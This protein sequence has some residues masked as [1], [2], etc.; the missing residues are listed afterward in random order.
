MINED[1]QCTS[2]IGWRGLPACS[3]GH[4][5]LEKVVLTGNLVSPVARSPGC[6]VFSALSRNSGRLLIDESKCGEAIIHSLW[7]WKGYWLANTQLLCAFIVFVVT[8]PDDIWGF[9]PLCDITE[10]PKL[11]H[12][13]HSLLP[14]PPANHFHGDVE[15]RIFSDDT[16]CSFDANQVSSSLRFLSYWFRRDSGVVIP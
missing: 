2:Y 14:V 9:P 3:G 12:S 7:C 13:I 10:F 16:G 8:W 6:C 5:R 11:C 1:H 15:R 4:S